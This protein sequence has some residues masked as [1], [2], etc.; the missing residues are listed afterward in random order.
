MAPPAK[1]RR[2]NPVEDSDDE[3]EQPRANNTLANYLVSSLSSPTRQEPP[4]PVKNSV[5]A[6][7]A[8][9]RPRGAAPQTNGVGLSPKRVRGGG[10]FNEKPKT[11]DLK[12]LFSKQAQRTTRS[13]TT[14]PKTSTPIDDIIS[15]PISEDDEISELKA[16]SSSLVGQHAR[17]RLKNGSDAGPVDA[18]SAS[19]KFLKPAKPPI[20]A[21]A[22]DDDDLRPWSERFGPRN[23]DELAVHK[24]KVTD[25][26]K[27]LEAVTTGR[28]RQRLLVLKGAAGSGKTTTV[29]LLAQDMGLELLE[30]KNPAG[31]HG[32]LSPSASVQ[33]DEFL[34][35]G[36]K[37]GMLDVEAPQASGTPTSS[38]VAAQ[39]RARRIMLVEEFPNTFSRSSSTLASFRR[40][41]LQYLAAPALARSKLNGR[42]QQEPVNPM[43]VI[44]SETL[45]TTTSATADSLTA[46]RLLGPEILRHPGV[47][48]MDF[49]AIAPTFL[50]KAMELIVQ[51]EARKSGRRKT[52]GP[53]VLNRL[54]EIGDI[55]SAISSLEFLC[56]KGDQEADW[57]AKVAFTKQKRGVR[58]AIGLTQGE[59]ETLEAI[60]QREA[61]LGIFHAV[62]KVVYNKRDEAP[63]PDDTVE[64]LPTFLAEFARPNRSQV[65]IDSLIDE[66]GTDTQTFISALHE[67]YVLSCE[68]TEPM[69]SSTSMDYVNECIEY[70]SLSDLLCPSRDVFFGGNGFGLSG[71]DG[72]GYHLRQDEMT[73]QLAVRGMLFSL[74][75]PVKRKP[76]GVLKGSEAFKM[77]YPTSI[78]LWKA[79][80]EIGGLPATTTPWTERARRQATAA[81]SESSKAEARPPMWLG[82]TARREMLLDRLPY[83]AHM[84]RGRRSGIHVGDL[85]KVVSMQGTTVATDDDDAVGGDGDGPV[86]EAWATDR[87]SEEASPRRRHAGVRAGEMSG[88]VAQKLVLSDDDIE[89]D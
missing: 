16:S 13:S 7:T 35:R 69:D 6:S 83:M 8:Q 39:D 25:V 68:S 49:N 51:K 82:S 47:T 15:D 42:P 3:A 9:R 59:T 36:G 44:I 60:T 17:K 24:K 23:L 48:V 50:A 70:L 89:D 54:G 73:F 32:M 11:A 79:K 57:G 4:S 43:V 10:R 1:R 66:I 64:R 85:E 76:T 62:G 55:R 80:E 40:S 34:G 72:S 38:G 37:F 2:R 67:N 22:L 27:W 28:I 33:F 46:H 31:S 18:P 20:V 88:L 63:P 52:P 75:H 41:I 5:T 45:L 19:R 12:T 56:L 74:P 30:W 87:P 84:A 53:L 86:G 78:K 71:R 14:N 29:R 65:P 21:A 26:R 61:S 77:F 58:D 81:S